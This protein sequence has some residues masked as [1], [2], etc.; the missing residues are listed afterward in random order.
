MTDQVSIVGRE[1]V[2]AGLSARQAGIRERIVRAQKING[3][4]L[5]GYVKA[6]KLSGQVLKVRTGRLRRSIHDS[7]RESGDDITMAVGTNVE[8][9]KPFEMGFQGTVE[10]R[11]HLRTLTMVFGRPVDPKQI[12]VRAHPMKMNIPERSFLRTSLQERKELMIGRLKAAMEGS[13]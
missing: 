6:T 12:T 2:I 7:L 1:Q 4:D 5:S 11:E 13:E 3:A 9:A 8:Y 10:V